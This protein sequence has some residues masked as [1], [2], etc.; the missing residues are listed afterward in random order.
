VP[1][2]AAQHRE[3]PG[4]GAPGNAQLLRALLPR[5][6][7][8]HLRE[9]EGG[10]PAQLARGPR[11]R[12]RDAGGEARE[13]LVVPVPG[14][15]RGDLL[16]LLADFG[17]L[18]AAA[19]PRLRELLHDRDDWRK[20]EAAWALRRA[21]GD[22]STAVDALTS[23]IQPLGTGSYLPVHL[24]AM[25]Y[26]AAITETSGQATGIARA[27]LANPRR[28]ASSGG[29]RT[30]DEDDQIRAAAAA[31]LTSRTTGQPG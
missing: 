21:T 12:V 19:Q 22:A 18:A 9:L 4:G 7:G 3:R 31:Y 17:E 24:A 2:S 20:T 28:L 16:G 27:V 6:A 1:E 25:R 23:V 29:W 30:Y 26:L 10:E 14:K 8:G 15:E 5:P 13:M 11:G